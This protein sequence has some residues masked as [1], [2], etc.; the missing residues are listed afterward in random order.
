[1]SFHFKTFSVEQKYQKPANSLIDHNKQITNS[2]SVLK[3]WLS[4][5]LIEVA[6]GFR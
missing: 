5:L 4:E 6:V 2:R 1:M 3:L